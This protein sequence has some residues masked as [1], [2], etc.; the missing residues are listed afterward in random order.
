MMTSIRKPHVE[1]VLFSD[2]K[3]CRLPIYTYQ[4]ACL[5]GQPTASVI[6]SGILVWV[7]PGESVTWVEAK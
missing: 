5:I 2:G 7:I 1:T 4:G 3:A 6:R